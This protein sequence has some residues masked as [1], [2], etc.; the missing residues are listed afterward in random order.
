MFEHPKKPTAEDPVR[1][2]I[3]DDSAVVRARLTKELGVF[4]AIEVVGSAPDPFVARE[5][6]G[7][8]R[9]EVLILDL[10][11]PRMDGLTFLRKIMKFCPMPTIIV[12]SL[13][14]RGADMA[15]AC[16]QAGAID[17]LGKP[18]EVYS[19]ADLSRELARIVMGARLV[20][21]SR[22]GQAAASVQA[23]LEGA[24]VDVTTNKVIAVGASTGGTDALMQL[25]APLPAWMHG[26]LL[27]QHMPEHFTTSF[28]ARL[29]EVG[30]M[31]V[32]EAQDGDTV[33]RG[34]ALLAPGGQQM[35]LVR[36]GSIHTVRVAPG[37]LVCRHAPSVEVL[38]ESVARN[39]RDDS[40][41]VML[42]GMGNDGASGMRSMHTAG[43][44][45]VAQD[46][47]SCVVFGM[48]KEAIALGG[49]DEVIR[50]DLIPQRIVDFAG[51]KTK[52]KG[53]L[54]G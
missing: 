3:V 43:A 33:E 22:L 38:F 13:T 29:N 45:T 31:E 42:T 40:M 36:S 23:P 48:P 32:R 53:K 24:A 26:M 49:V 1:V 54:A 9:P 16:L 12:S 19:I 41:G 18:T 39:A 35:K 7:K 10:E 50:L 44:L 30:Q 47:S 52:G 28:A 8:L 25:M 27:V 15:T 11:M 14:P 4:P 17:V 51:G 20:N 37:P 2:L 5:M 6:M 21:L 34:V 46:E